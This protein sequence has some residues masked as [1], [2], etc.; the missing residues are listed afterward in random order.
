[1]RARSWNIEALAGVAVDDRDEAAPAARLERDLAVALGEDRVVTAEPRARPRAEAGAPLAHDDRARGHALAVEDLDA[2]H[3]GRRVAPVPRRSESLFVRHLL[4]LLCLE[5]GEGA[6]A[7]AVRPLVLERRRDLLS[8]PAAGLLGDLLD[9]HVRVAARE[10]RRRLGRLLLRG[11][12][13]A[14]PLGA[15]QLD[16]DLRQLRPEPRLAAVAGL[17]PV[18]ADHDLV[19]E[20]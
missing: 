19:A 7:L 13:R 8:R 14:G 4:V 17:R 20:L 10:L 1:M 16:L 18:L 3:L 5:R 9:R 6:L 15:D 2:E 12:G 11:R